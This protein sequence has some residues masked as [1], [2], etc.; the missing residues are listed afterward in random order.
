MKIYDLD[1]ELNLF[2]GQP[3]KALVCSTIQ[4]YMIWVK[5][6]VSQ[7]G[8]YL[9]TSFAKIVRKEFLAFLFKDKLKKL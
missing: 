6:D 2:L 3:L 1:V 8:F 7:I 4:V 9:K 5:I